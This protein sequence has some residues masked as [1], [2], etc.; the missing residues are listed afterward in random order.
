MESMIP[1]LSKIMTMV[2][3]V[4]AQAPMLIIL[5]NLKENWNYLTCKTDVGLELSQ[6]PVVTLHGVKQNNKHGAEFLLRPQ[7]SL[8]CLTMIHVYLTIPL[9]RMILLFVL[10]WKIGHKIPVYR[11]KW[12]LRILYHALEKCSIQYFCSKILLKALT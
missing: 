7:C 1:G 4:L 10:H 3:G 2:S 8:F 5:P 11:R 9:E 6:R 12:E